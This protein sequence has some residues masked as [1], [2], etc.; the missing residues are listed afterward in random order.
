[1]K[2]TL[3]ALSFALVLFAVGCIAMHCIGCGTTPAQRDVVEVRARNGAD[4]VQYEQD[5]T[6]CRAEGRDAG[7]YGAYETCANDAAKRARVK[8]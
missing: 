6:T 1:M 7:S 2:S 3:E 8:P 4:L 5:L